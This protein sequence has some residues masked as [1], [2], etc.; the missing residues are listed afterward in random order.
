MYDWLI[1]PLKC[2][3]TFKML[4][5]VGLEVLLIKYF[6][7][8]LSRSWFK[9]FMKHGIFIKTGQFVHVT[10]LYFPNFKIFDD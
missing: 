1:S 5:A 8:C 10:Q 2:G 6:E 4:W 3:F 9:M 7:D